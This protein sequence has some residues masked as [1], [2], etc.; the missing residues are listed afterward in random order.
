MK[1]F[2][3]SLV[4]VVTFASLLLGGQSQAAPGPAAPTKAVEL[5][6]AA[7]SRSRASQL[8]LSLLTQRAA[9]RA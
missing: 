1:G 4:V 7:A 8:P 9:E 5:A 2:G 3:I 6:Q